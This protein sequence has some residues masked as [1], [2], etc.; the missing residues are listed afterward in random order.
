MPRIAGLGSV[1]PATAMIAEQLQSQ[2][3]TRCSNKGKH[4]K[5]ITVNVDMR[6]HQKVCVVLTL[7]ERLHVPRCVQTKDGNSQQQQAGKASNK[8]QLYQP[9]RQLQPQPQPQPQQQQHSAA[10]PCSLH[11]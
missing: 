10:Q 7:G 8:Q 1:S 2:S 11:L 4:H 5:G 3:I 6:M 9:Q